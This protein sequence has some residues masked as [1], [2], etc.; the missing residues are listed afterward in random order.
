M[1]IVLKPGAT[2]KDIQHIEE[3][4]KQLPREQQNEGRAF[5]R[6]DKL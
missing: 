3:K 6:S 5:G 1:I 4:I 2:K